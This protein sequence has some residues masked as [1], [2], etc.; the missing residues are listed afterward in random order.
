M[1]MAIL[2]FYKNKYRYPK[3]SEGLTSYGTALDCTP[4]G[5]NLRGGTLRVK[6]TMTDFMSCN[7]L[8]LNR[9]GQTI[10][11][12]I[13]DVR[14]RTEDSFEITYSVD[15]WR[16]YKSKVSLG[17]Q[18]IKRSPAA[19]FLKDNLLGSTQPYQDIKSESH[20]IGSAAQRIAVV[21]IRASAGEVF[22]NVP[23]QP[24]P[25]Q[26]YL[27][28]YPVNRWQ[29]CLPLVN[30][31]ETLAAN[32]ETQNVVTIYSVPFFDISSF[33][34]NP[35]IIQKTGGTALEPISGFKCIT[36]TVTMASKLYNET[37]IT[38]SNANEL[39]KSD[40]SIQVVIP[41]AGILH[42]PDE[43]LGK[44]TIKLRQDIDIFSG[45]CNYMLTTGSNATG[46]Y[47][48]YGS[49]V[50]G[51]SISSIPIISDPMDT[52]LSQNQNALAT[53]LIGDVASIAMGAAMM[54]SPAAAG[55]GGAAAALGGSM[56]ASSGVN[57]LMNTAAQLGDAGNHYANPPAFLGQALA[58]NFS[59]VFWLVT[60][61]RKVTNA[62]Q[63]NNT[64]GY[65]YNMVD[66]LSFPASGFIQTESCMVES[67]DG[68]VPRWALEEINAMFN[69][70]VL[71]KA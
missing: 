69:N 47:N 22:S 12:W 60:R 8:S 36:D 1:D 10:W 4:V 54:A 46:D 27:V 64:F 18:F 53:S 42:L 16:T 9:D 55:L 26:F 51:S 68:S 7:Y 57:G 13:D 61:S 49:S 31:M 23:V 32:A 35:L 21:Q 30:L 3:Y 33:P 15:A 65:P 40:H 52:Y 39:M 11:A 66:S 29:D 45:A 62:A 58:A 28:A 71:V 17:T 14:F 25:Y 70:G 50:R 59:G 19:T 2:R 34:D 20:V 48:I 41:E 6:G 24:N 38:I 67:T 37:P 56:S 63:V 44:G 5:I 43:L